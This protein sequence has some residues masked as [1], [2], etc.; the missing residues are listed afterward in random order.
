MF[1][2]VRYLCVGL[3]N[4]HD[5]LANLLIEYKTKS[6]FFLQVIK[7]ESSFFASKNHHLGK[8]ICYKGN[9]VAVLSD[10]KTV[11]LLTTLFL[12][13]VIVLFYWLDMSNVRRTQNCTTQLDNHAA[14]F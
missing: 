10:I 12:F 2:D 13:L 1:F 6:V 11:N 4:T 8:S 9:F 7:C 14:V 3:E 5:L